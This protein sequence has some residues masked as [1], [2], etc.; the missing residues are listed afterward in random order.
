MERV[1]Q[2]LDRL[3]LAAQLHIADVLDFSSDELFDAVL[4]DAPCSAT[5]TIRRHPELPFIKNEQ[6]IAELADLQARL[7]AHAAK[8]V[9]SG[10]S[11][12]YCTCSLEPEEGEAQVERFLEGHAEYRRLPLAAKDV[13]GQGQFI[14]A[15]G[16]LRTLPS[17]NIG[18]EQ[19][20]D[21]FYAA[22]LVRL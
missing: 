19:G 14:T 20:L 16:D 11:L 2:N 17:M 22:R 5:G 4:L 10:G 7:L 9:K 18:T 13:G 8:L 1:K 15:D 12:I 21:G 6:Q 3:K